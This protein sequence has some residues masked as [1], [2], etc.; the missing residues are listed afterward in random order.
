MEAG[1]FRACARL[2]FILHRDGVCLC[3]RRRRRPG[4]LLPR[5]FTLTERPPKGRACPA[6]CFLWHCPGG[7]PRSAL[8]T[9]RPCDARTFLPQTIPLGNGLPATVLK[10][11]YRRDNSGPDSVVPEFRPHGRGRGLVGRGRSGLIPRGI[12]ATTPLRPQ[13]LRRSRLRSGRL[14]RSTRSTDSSSR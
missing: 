7:F 14:H 8:P 10:D 9:I 6:V 5:R 1:R 4:E 12:S 3:G 11:R 2:R 13:L